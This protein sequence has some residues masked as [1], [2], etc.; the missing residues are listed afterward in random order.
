[1]VGN[2]VIEPTITVA[3]NQANSAY[4]QA[5]AAYTA[6]NT[7]QTTAQNAYGQANLAYTAANTAQTTAQNAYGA[8]NTAQT[9]AQN[10][11]GAANTAQ[12]TAQN[13][14]GAAN[15][16]QTT[17]QNAYGQ[18]NA[19]Y[20]QA[21]TAANT[22]RVSANGGSTLSGKQLNFVN[23]ANVTI[24]VTDSGDGNANIA[25]FSIGGS[26]GGD[27]T[28]AYNQA[29][30]AYAQANLAYTAANTAQTTA[31]NA[32]GQANSAYGAANTA[33]TTAQNAYGQA[34]AAYGQANSAYGAA[35][36][37]QT[38]AQNAYGAANSAASTVRVSQN[39][40]S[41]LSGKQLNFVNTATV[42][43]TV[44]DSANGNANISFT[45]VGAAANIS[46][47]D[48]GTQV[49][50]AVE[51]IN[52]V[53]DGV[54][55]TA[56]G[57]AVTV[58]IPGGGGGGSLSNIKVSQNSTG[59]L[60]ANSINFVNTETV[61]VSVSAG[62]NG[63]ANV[64]FNTT[65]SQNKY[66]TTTITTE[67]IDTFSAT[68]YRSGKYQL[69]VES[70]YGFA[71]LEAMII[72]DGTTAN[73]VEY[74]KSTIGSNVGVFS[75]DVSSGQVR[76][77]FTANDPSTQISYYRNLLKFLRNN[78]VIDYLPEDLLYDKIIGDLMNA[79]SSNL[80]NSDL[81]NV[82]DA[83]V[84]DLMNSGHVR[85]KNDGLVYDLLEGVT[86]ISYNLNNSINHITPT[87][88]LDEALTQT[89][90]NLPA[91]DVM[92]SLTFTPTDFMLGYTTLGQ[93]LMSGGAITRFDSADRNMG[94]DEDLDLMS[95]DDLREYSDLN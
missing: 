8:A 31:Q 70:L 58:T 37:A 83:F 21:N 75:A 73:I 62:V 6:A 80:S 48:E 38:T 66:N 89:F 13:A 95:N 77:R 78:F 17:A 86:K 41:I 81:L 27:S 64:S 10:A 67:T 29:N 92:N 26:G 82:T 30:S 42:T 14:Y 76:L 28:A 33:Q 57:S 79:I 72:H 44:S 3:H 23:T 54:T 11:Y 22:V 46:V 56:T 69:Q 85:N 1:M 74:G 25:I 15:T 65:S 36:T 84:N 5:N 88:L 94:P 59:T 91:F 51:S 50:S 43:I 68:T 52:F 90:D 18:A 34:N 39:N 9:T 60:N 12:T 7:A 35:N 71:A 4:G 53:G 61:S 45:S 93:D 2:I 40:G 49:A 20:G 32:Y 19:A 55:A 63:N 47:R 24:A 16:A 87:D